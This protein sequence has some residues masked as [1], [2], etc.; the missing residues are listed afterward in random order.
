MSNIQKDG[1]Y[2]WFHLTATCIVSFTFIG[3]ADSIGIIVAVFIDHLNESNAKGGCIGSM[4]YFLALALSPIAVYVHERVGFRWCMFIASLLYAFS[5]CVTPF[6]TD[7]NIV[8][9]TYSIPFGC[10]LSLVS[11]LSVITLRE[12]FSKY[13]GFAVGLRFGA[14]AIGSVAV[15]FVLPIILA[16]VG[17]KMTFVSLLV[18]APIVLC[19]GFV[20]RHHH[21]HQDTELRKRDRKSAINLYKEFLQDKSFTIC[22]IAIGMY[23]FTCFIPLIFLVRYAVTLGYTLSKAKFLLVVRGLTTSVTR[24]IAGRFG[25]KALTHRKVKTITQFTFIL[26][27]VL[28]FICSFIR[29]FPLLL[30][31]MALIGIVEGVL[32]IRL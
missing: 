26:F 5:L 27:G 25:D 12:Y 13:F 1:P 24:P 9:L 28:N 19:Y 17:Y 2:S 14:N 23:F 15:S 10:S 21:M 22:L 29:S 8:F 20:A 18:F 11:T 7:L 30:L 31:Y 32:V 3:L 16:E 4:V 6:M